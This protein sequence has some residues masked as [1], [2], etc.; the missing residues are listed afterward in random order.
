MNKNICQY[1]LK[2]YSSQYLLKKYNQFL[3]NVLYTLFNFL[4]IFQLFLAKTT[5]KTKTKIYTDSN[6]F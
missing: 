4:M 3:I 5:F 6:N 1:T 2:M